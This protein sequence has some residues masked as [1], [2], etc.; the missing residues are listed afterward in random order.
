MCNNF[1]GF[2]PG[3]KDQALG[4]FGSPYLEPTLIGPQKLVR[5]LTGVVVL[6]ALH[7]FAPCPPWLGAIPSVRLIS[8]SHHWVGPASAALGLRIHFVLSQEHR[9]QRPG[10]A[11][12][13]RRF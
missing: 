13:R 7:K 4:F 9:L 5:I 12:P 3:A 2:G 11:S 10:P 8:N 6:K 1:V